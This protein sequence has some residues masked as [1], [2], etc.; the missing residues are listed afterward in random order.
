M[1][2]SRKIIIQ[3]LAIGGLCVIAYALTFGRSWRREVDVR[4]G[5]TRWVTT[6]FG[7]GIYARHYRETI[8]SEW[9][10][11]PLGEPMWISVEHGFSRRAQVTWCYP[12]I[13]SHLRS[14]DSI[15]LDPDARRTY[16][17]LILTD[18]ETTGRVCRVAHRCN[19]VGIE[20]NLHEDWLPPGTITIER[21]ETAWNR[22]KPAQQAGDGDA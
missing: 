16:V 21:L 19:N 17:T 6:I 4:S 15:V 18:L 8:V 2:R 11:D 12:S 20:L 7:V 22:Q 3:L 9:V 1:K 5:T 14:L 13:P 10:G